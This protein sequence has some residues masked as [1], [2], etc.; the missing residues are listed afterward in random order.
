MALALKVTSSASV[1]SLGVDVA[2][3]EVLGGSLAQ[4]ATIV[5]SARRSGRLR[6]RF[7]DRTCDDFLVAGPGPA[8]IRDGCIV[9]NFRVLF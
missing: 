9:R 8:E 4:A 3:G 6:R 7:G 2:V 5:P 1:K